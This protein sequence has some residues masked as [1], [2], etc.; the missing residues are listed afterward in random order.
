[1]NWL[2]FGL[3]GLFV[4]V[5]VY[6][7]CVSECVGVLCVDED[8]NVVVCVDELFVGVWF[9]WGIEFVFFCGDEEFFC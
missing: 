3:I 4:C 7:V 8:L 9:E 5:C 1:M 2:M 6:D